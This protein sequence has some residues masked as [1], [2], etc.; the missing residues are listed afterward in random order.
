MTAA[1]EKKVRAIADVWDAIAERKRSR[2]Q[3]GRQ[4]TKAEPK[5]TEPRHDDGTEMTSADS[6]GATAEEK[7][8]RDA[9]NAKKE[10]AERGGQTAALNALKKQMAGARDCESCRGQAAG[11]VWR[12]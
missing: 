2:E 5:V 9:A 8:K 1:E 10:K 11:R 12:V 3:D 6:Q 7:R 4:T